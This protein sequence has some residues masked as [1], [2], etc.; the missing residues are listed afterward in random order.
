MA[1]PKRAGVA[2]LTAGLALSCAT[3]FGVAPAAAAVPDKCNAN[4]QSKTFDTPGSNVTF[5]IKLC[6]SLNSSSGKYHAYAMG[7]WSGGG[8]YAVGEMDKFLLLLRLERSDAI[9]RAE[10][11]EFRS[12]IN[13]VPSDSFRPSDMPTIISG[14]CDLNTDATN[15]GGGKWTAD[16]KIIYNIQNDGDGDKTWELGGSPGYDD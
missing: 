16:G 12:G 8:N 5:K 10:S 4:Y 13:W 9:M 3:T 2:A 6:V 14:E 15:S 1:W 7:S 11:C